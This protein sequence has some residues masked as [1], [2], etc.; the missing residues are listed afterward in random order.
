MRSVP[1]RAGARLRPGPDFDWEALPASVGLLTGR[2]ST[3]I[4]NPVA[5]GEIW[6]LGAAGA[7]GTGTFGNRVCVGK[8]WFGLGG[9]P[10][11]RRVPQVPER[12]SV[13]R[14]RASPTFR[15]GFDLSGLFGERP[16]ASGIAERHRTGRG[17]E[18]G[19]A[20]GLVQ[21]GGSEPEGTQRY[22][23][24]LNRSFPRKVG[25]G[26]PP[27]VFCLTDGASAREAT[28][29]HHLPALRWHTFR[30]LSPLVGE[31]GEAMLL[32]CRD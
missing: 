7:V 13:Y 8:N 14:N 1:A 5:C 24:F 4:R 12:G 30:G 27:T 2:K 9:A 21:V 26:F 25:L 6:E 32:K 11:V 17:L 29:N 23:G 28:A 22:H 16:R 10:C 20:P 31:L 3:R 18:K 15:R 19:L